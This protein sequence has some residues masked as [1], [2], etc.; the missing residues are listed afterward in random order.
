MASS[1]LAENR[2]ALIIGNGAY[3]SVGNLANPPNDAKLMAKTLRQVGFEVIERINAN[4]KTMKRAIKE[5]G[6]KLEAAGKD[7][8]GL[9]YYAGHGVQVGGT[10]YLIPVRV[11]IE[12]EAD[13]SIEAVSADDVQV[14]MAY[15]GS[16]LNII[17]MDACRN[18]PF[19]RGFRA[20]SRGLAKMDATKGTLIAYATSPGDV[21][22]DGKGE[23]SPYTQALAKALL[24]PGLTVERMF[25]KVR[26][27]VVAATNSKQVPW[28]SSSLTGRDFYFMG[29]AAETSPAQKSGPAPTTKVDKEAMFWEAVKDSTDAA[30]FKAYL[31]QFP[32]GSFTALARLKIKRYGKVKSA[33]IVRPALKPVTKPKPVPKHEPKEGQ[34]AALQKLWQELAKQSSAS[35]LLYFNQ[36]DGRTSLEGIG[37]TREWINKYPGDYKRALGQL[38]KMIAVSAEFRSDGSTIVRYNHYKRGALELTNPAPSA[39][40]TP[41]Q[42]INRYN[43]VLMKLHQSI[44]KP[45]LV[46]EAE[47]RATVAAILSQ[48]E[49]SPDRVRAPMQQA[50]LTSAKQLFQVSPLD[51]EM[52]TLRAANIRAQPTTKSAKMGK[53]TAGRFVT[54]T[55]HTEV[56]GSGWYR[57]E[58][59]GQT[60]YVFG[61]L[62]KQQ[63]AAAMPRPIAQSTNKASKGHQVGDVFKD[64]PRCPEMVVVPAGNFN[65]GSDQGEEDEKPVH[66]VI[67]PKPFAVG[68][69]EI[70]QAEW[71]SFMGNNPSLFKGDRKPVET[72]S[73]KD[74]KAFIDALNAKTGKQYRLLSES[75]WEYIARAGS[76]TKYPWGN[77]INHSQ[78]RYVN[79]NLDT[80]PVDTYKANAFG[81]HGTVGNIQEWVEDCWH[82]NYMGAPKDGSSWIDKNC[83]K[84][85]VR[86]GTWSYEPKNLRSSFRSRWSSDSAHGSNGFRVA[87]GLSGK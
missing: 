85:V 46:K 24:S 6:N 51:E 33:A 7:S 81:V 40:E 75:E 23:N 20:A 87:R 41:E 65:M 3:P 31:E 61:S 53:L 52:L 34:K 11:D 55:G 22:A 76:K 26:N 69:Y 62:L 64:C 78:A 27:D 8:V 19:K 77:T 84:R 48:A 74:A 16:R 29:G 83:V 60:G 67:I 39:N 13:V 66:K 12:D 79:G 5:F 50:A 71:L 36:T 82:K 54:V 17:I 2:V 32:K 43:K 86:G 37:D 49:F 73:W 59:G 28:E 15:A 38:A 1:A 58:Q 57:I 4:Q 44:F 35:P 25:K 9:F 21:A 80:S 47:V 56:A 10:N 72:I 70:T 30:D 14:Q 45:E 42:R 18:N 63:L 68:K